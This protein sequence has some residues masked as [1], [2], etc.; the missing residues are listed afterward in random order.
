MSVSPDLRRVS[1][2][3]AAPRS[4][5]SDPLARIVRSELA[6]L[7]RRIDEGHY[8]EEVLRRFG[9]VGAFLGEGTP[10]RPAPLFDAIAAMARV[11]QECL[12]TAFCMWCQDT[13]AWYLQN[14]DN[15]ALRQRLLPDAVTGRVLGGTG[16]SNPMKAI[17]GIEPMRLSGRPTKDGF[18]VNGSLPWVSNLR[19]THHFGTAFEVEGQRRQIMA[20][21]D[22]SLPGIRLGDGARFLALD[23]TRTC[24]VAFRDVFIPRS[25]VLADPAASFIARI[26]AG[27]ILLQ[28]GMGLGVIRGCAEVMQR[29]DESCGELNRFLDDRPELFFEALDRLSAQISLLARTPFEAAREYQRKVLE[30]RLA[31]SEWSLRAAQAALLHAGAKGYVAGAAAQRKLREAYFIAI[32]TPAIKHLRK[33]LAALS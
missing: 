17:A 33:E 4:P 2:M 15:E 3:S 18:I 11:G 21:V 5:P 32:V 14:T 30:V 13:F 23:G 28:T 29:A 1:G 10:Q 7:V 16:L 25:L 31:T 20:M 6:P 24:S 9:E 27:F 12:A 22:C 26:K 19:A 8:P